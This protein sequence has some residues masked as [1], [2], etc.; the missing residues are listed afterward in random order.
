MILLADAFNNFQNMC[1][2]IYALDPARLFS[3]P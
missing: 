1:L 3:T 2:E